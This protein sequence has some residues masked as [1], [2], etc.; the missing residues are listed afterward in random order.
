MFVCVGCVGH[1]E[2]RARLLVLTKVLDQK[3]VGVSSEEI[4][5]EEDILVHEK[6]KGC[7]LHV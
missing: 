6:E 5:F 7:R 2:R 4:G 3:R 1:V